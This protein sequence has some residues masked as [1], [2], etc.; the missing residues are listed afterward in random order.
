MIDFP[1][2]KVFQTSGMKN[3]VVRFVGDTIEKSNVRMYVL[4]YM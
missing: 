2:K 4:Y 3:Y 1:R